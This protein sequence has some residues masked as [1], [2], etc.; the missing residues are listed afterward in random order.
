MKGSALFSL[1]SLLFFAG[2]FLASWLGTWCCLK[3]ALQHNILD[4]PN[5]R[6]SHLVPTPRGGGLSVLVVFY[7][8]G[9]YL[10]L[11]GNS[12]LPH[13]PGL[14]ACGLGVA[15]V[16]FVDDL[17]RLSALKR[18]LIHF[19]SVFATVYVFL[20]EAAFSNCGLP[21]MAP[22]VMRFFSLFGIVWLLNLFNFMDGIDGIAG[23][24]T[25]SV[26]LGAGTLL[27]CTG[28]GGNIFLLLLVLAVAMAGFL[29]W[30]WSPAKIFMGD[31]CSAFLGFCFGVFVLLTSHATA[32]T[33]WTWGLL[34]ATFV[35]D[36]TVTLVVRI[37]RG[38]QFYQAHRSH[39]YQILARR[40]GS[41]Q[42]TT[43][44]YLAVNCLLLF[45]LACFSVYKPE[46]GSILV[47]LAYG[48][49]TAICL[50][51]GAGTSNG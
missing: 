40:T 17:V 33:I 24:E 28:A 48:V 39:A 4:H 22:S 10:V 1:G 16:G 35:V 14:A 23:M 37:L 38:E 9:G 50:V 5:A 31:S 51:I 49:L 13:A 12:V 11:S 18:I 8:A 2:V 45:P 27:Y 7:L 6:S 29:V 21:W 19:F 3:V 26:A 46:Y 47:F 41:H 43:L 30:N 44:Y 34:L 36:A 20:P 15:M 25:L 32:L 42:T